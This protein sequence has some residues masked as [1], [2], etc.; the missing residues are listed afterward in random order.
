MN[1]CDFSY[2][3]YREILSLALQKG[4]NFR[5]F[6]SSE[7]AESVIYLRH[8]ID[9]DIIG[10][11]ELAQI[12]HRLGVTSTYFIMLDSPVYNPLEDTSRYC[13]D[14]IKDFG[15]NI[16]L[17]IDAA[18]Y[19]DRY[20]ETML[21]ALCGTLPL[22]RVISFHKPAADVPGR[23]F[24]YFTSTYARKFF[25]DIKYVSDSQ[26]KWRDGCP[27]RWLDVEKYPKA[28]ILTHPIHWGGAA[29][30]DNARQIVANRIVDIKQY[31]KTIHLGIDA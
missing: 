22:K 13:L 28:Q 17:H 9:L 8:D 16:G 19:S 15:H 30:I 26:G 2:T 18:K 27:C 21:T 24:P 11:V 12:E 1:K 3:H 29:S 5:D 31:L 10:A 6:Q 4:Y 14:K 20:I 25:S 23:T 7:V